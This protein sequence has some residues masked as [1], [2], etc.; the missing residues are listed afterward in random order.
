M[1]LTKE[2]RE[3]VL[4]W[5]EADDKVEIYTTSTKAKSWCEKARFTLER[6]ERYNNKPY[7]WIFS[8]P[9][10]EFRFGKR[11]RY[12]LSE[13]EKKQRAERLKSARLSSKFS[14]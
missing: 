5:T 6:V 7:C 3:L 12:D 4:T 8:C 9:V 10:T 2:E 13:E 14:K 1:K 11:K